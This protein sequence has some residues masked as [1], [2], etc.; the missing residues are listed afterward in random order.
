MAL[1]VFVRNWSTGVGDSSSN[2]ST[3]GTSAAASTS[4]SSAAA[5]SSSSTR[6]STPVSSMRISEPASSSRVLSSAA[7]CLAEMAI[8]ALPSGFRGSGVSSGNGATASL[9]AGCSGICSER[10]SSALNATPQPP[11]RTLPAA[12]FKTSAVTRNAVLQSGHCVYIVGRY[13]L[14]PA[15]R[16]QVWPSCSLKTGSSNSIQ[17]SYAAITAGACSHNTPDNASIPPPET[18]DVTDSAN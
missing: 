12:C 4:G 10:Y 17:G 3:P 6:H 16:D 15:S 11:Q 5:S 7:L 14:L 2:S 18:V 1:G 8:G 13:L 9:V